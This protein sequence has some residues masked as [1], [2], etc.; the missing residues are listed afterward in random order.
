MFYLPLLEMRTQG[1]L[2]RSGK[3]NYCYCGCYSNYY[4]N[5][6]CYSREFRLST[7]ETDWLRDNEPNS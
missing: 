3:P 2:Y 5:Y 4:S 7:S 6:Y 1:R